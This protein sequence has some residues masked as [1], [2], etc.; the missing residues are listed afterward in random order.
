M[1]KF[2]PVKYIKVKRKGAP[3]MEKYILKLIS[4]KNGAWKKYKNNK[5]D[6]NF[7]IFKNLRNRVKQEIRNAKVK[8]YHELFGSN[9]SKDI[10]NSIRSLGVKTR[11]SKVFC[12]DF[13]VSP[14]E[15]NDHYASVSTVDNVDAV[16]EAIEKYSNM[17]EPNHEKFFFKYIY[18]LDIK[19]AL[20]SIT[21]KAIG[22]DLISVNFL[23]LIVDDIIPVMEHIF[24][25]S[26][27]SSVYPQIWK[28]ANINPIPKCN[29]PT[30][31]KDFRPVSVLCVIAKA[32]E[33]IVHA[34][35]TSY[36]NEFNIMNPL[37]SGFRRGHSTVTALAK[38]TDD[39][40]K[41]IDKR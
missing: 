1:D 22:V 34:Q 24:N 33:K 13:P 36:M 16:N 17:T 2:A 12:S 10:W 5:T 30:Q 31:S 21:S 38:V 28:M 7:N 11:S 19:R 25:Y 9:S 23:K 18:P 37:Q 35:I 26:L 39:L 29:N 15:L 27:Q 4:K 14:N 40:R 20:C 8:Y 32:F 6:V 3:W 41:S